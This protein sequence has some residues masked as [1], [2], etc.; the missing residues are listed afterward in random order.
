MDFKMNIKTI[1]VALIIIS[2]PHTMATNCE[3]R[4]F[5]LTGAE[6]ALDGKPS[7]LSK[8][9]EECDAIETTIYSQ[10]YQSALEI[11]CTSDN[12]K[13]AA[14]VGIKYQGTCPKELEPLFLAGYNTM[15]K[16]IKGKE[17]V[18]ERHMDEMRHDAALKESQRSILLPPNIPQ[19]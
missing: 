9:Q 3:N 2:S 1:A 5:E 15:I 14:Q 19:R 18:H 16:Q 10:G 11:F 13:R 8:I 12:G 6:D 4:D 17:M 7:Q